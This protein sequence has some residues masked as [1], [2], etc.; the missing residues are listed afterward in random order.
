[1]SVWTDL[2]MLNLHRSLCRSALLLLVVTSGCASW[3]TSEEK[4]LSRA[5]PAPRRHPGGAA[6][7]VAFVSIQPPRPVVEGGRSLRDRTEGAEAP[8]DGAVGDIDRT[9]E[10]EA[11]TDGAVGDIN[12][13]EE[14]EAPTGQGGRSLRDRT[15]EAEAPTGGAVG[16]VNRTEEAEAPTGQGGRSLRDRTERAGAPTDGAVGDIAVGDIAVGDIAVGD[17]GAVPEE[18]HEIDFATLV[19]LEDLAPADP[20]SAPTGGAIGDTAVDDLSAAR[21]HEDIWRRIDETVVAPEVRQALRRNGLRLG[22]V[23]GVAD[24][25][26]RL[27]RIR[28]HPGPTASVLEIAEV[29][30]DLSHQARLITCRIGKRYELPVRQPSAGEQAVLVT[31]GGKTVGQTL[32]Q[33]QPLFALRATAADVNSIRLSLR[34]EIQHGAARQTWVGSDAALRIDNRRA[35]WSFEELAA[36][37]PL[38]KGGILVAGCTY[39]AFGLGQQMFTGTTADG[40]DDQVL[41]V[42][43][44]ADLPELI[45]R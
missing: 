2:A 37:V 26:E 10:A 21:V 45:D 28:R 40:D 42:I 1:M 41:M 32:S 31:L 17:N 27:S 11:P 36:E 15:E 14:A 35:S 5:L 3:H 24:F 20:S 25:N 12:R 13:T 8:T 39:P 7:E 23:Q 29:D 30:S 18:T 22:K 38:E 16:D 34:P 9:E 4:Q 33:P 6:L 43:R 19:A 44:V